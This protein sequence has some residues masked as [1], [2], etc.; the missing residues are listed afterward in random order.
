MDITYTKIIITIGLTV[1]GWLIAHHFTSKRNINNKRRELATEYLINTYRILTHD[2]SNRELDEKANIS[3]E[4]ILSDIQLF[5]S[6]EQ[7]TL[8][9]QLALDLSNGKTVELDSLIRSLR[10]DLR[11][12]LN[13]NQINED[14]RY[15]RFSNHTTPQTNKSNQ[16]TKQ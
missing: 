5:G 6:K 8:A 12:E 13:L 10:N 4:N 1:L 9:R 14:V 16:E 11:S 2:I 3:F 7:V 15:I